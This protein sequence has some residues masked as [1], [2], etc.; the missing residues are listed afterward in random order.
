[1]AKIETGNIATYKGR[2]PLNLAT[3]KG[4]IT[5]KNGEEFTAEELS[6]IPDATFNELVRSG[7]AAVAPKPKASPKAADKPAAE[8]EGDK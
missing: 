6:N 5:K 7:D 1:M 8:K 2:F 3:K 4:V